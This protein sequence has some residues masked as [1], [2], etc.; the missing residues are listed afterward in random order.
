[1]TQQERIT[2]KAKHNGVEKLPW[3]L[4]DGRYGFG[5]AVKAMPKHRRS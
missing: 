2:N 1:M 3:N 5:K 4:Q